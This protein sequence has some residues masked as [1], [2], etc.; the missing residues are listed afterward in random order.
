MP[1]GAI[2]VTNKVEQT[3][4]DIDIV[5]LLIVQGHKKCMHKSF[6]NAY[7][8]RVLFDKG[9][10]SNC[11]MPSLRVLLVSSYTDNR[12]DPDVFAL[13]DLISLMKFGPLG[14]YEG[15]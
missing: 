10:L 1:S 14:K 13:F 15:V 7:S 12:I 11:P 6:P 5:K 9:C 3:K 2:I 8:I 4:H